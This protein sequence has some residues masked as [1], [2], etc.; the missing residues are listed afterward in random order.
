M[1]LLIH[2]LVEECT[3][4]ELREKLN[5]LS[6]NLSSEEFMDFLHFKKNLL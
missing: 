5:S 3:A 6:N 2:K 4:S 1:D